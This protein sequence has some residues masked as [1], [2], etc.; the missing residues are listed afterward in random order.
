MRWRL[1][2]GDQ[3]IEL[4]AGEATREARAD[5][6]DVALPRR[7]FRDAHAMRALRAAVAAV[8]GHGPRRDRD[9][10]AVLRRGDELVARGRLRVARVERPFP[11]VARG[12]VEVSGVEGPTAPRGATT[13]APPNDALE[14]LRAGGIRLRPKLAITAIDH[15]F[16]PTHE[17]L[18]VRYSIMN[19]STYR[20]VVQV[21]ADQGGVLYERELTHAEKSNGSNKPFAWDGLISM[22]ARAGR[23]ANPLMA[24]FHVRIAADGGPEARAAFSILYAVITLGWGVHTPDGHSPPEGDRVRFAQYRLN[25]LEHDAGPVDGAMSPV[26]VKALRRFQRGA[27][28]PGTREV[29]VESGALDPDTFEAIKA[30]SPRVR[31]SGVDPLADDSRLYVDCNFFNDRDVTDLTRYSNALP[32]FESHD[33]AR[34]V[35]DRLERPYIPLEVLVQLLSKRGDCVIAPEAVGPARVAWEVDDGPEVATVSAALNPRAR[36]YVERART[37]GTSASVSGPRIDGDGDNAFDAVGGWRMPETKQWMILRWFPQVA[38]SRLEPYRFVE[39][40]VEVRGGVERYQLV[41]EAWEYPAGALPALTAR[42]QRA[43][44]APR[45]LGRTGQYFRH[46]TKGGD[47]AKIRVALTFQGLPNADALTA[48]HQDRAADLVAETGRW[49]VWRRIRISGYCQQTAPTRPVPTPDW[50]AVAAGWSEAFIDLEST[51][52]PA[53]DYAAIVTKDVYE[54]AILAIPASLRPA[55]VS[56]AADIV[57]R[58]TCIFGGRLPAQ[59]VLETA[60]HYVDRAIEYVDAWCPTALSAIAD[61]LRLEARKRSPEGLVIC[62]FRWTEPISGEDYSSFWVPPVPTTDPQARNRLSMHGGQVRLDGAVYM[63]VDNNYDASYYV[64]HECGH[65]QFL[66]HHHTGGGGVG[67]AS[68]YPDHHD[69]DQKECSMSYAVRGTAPPGVRYRYCGKCILHL[70]GWS[71]TRLPNRYVP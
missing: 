59:S 5:H 11:V 70:R 33:R 69:A 34:H 65:A 51:R 35:E 36:S 39:M 38:E 13:E 54:R 17:R 18:D 56:S 68:Q 8:D 57:Y 14:A 50:A 23:Y 3:E 9:D 12:L 55:G 30:A 46:S 22:G 21:V 66:A 41:T 7:F 16:A 64:L 37:V 1:R 71:A 58:P 15:H 63:N 60:K 67:D 10:A 28:K 31:W 20:V 2:D 43:T 42:G 48:L 24:P 61:V 40:Q 6:R 52:P 45:Y 4:L 62:D 27:Y 44:P 25:A 47:D 53:L 29:L 26:F 32:E 49:T 19:L